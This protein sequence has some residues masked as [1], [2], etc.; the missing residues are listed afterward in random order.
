M[1]HLIKVKAGNTHLQTLKAIAE[2]H[3]IQM[4]ELDEQRKNLVITLKQWFST[5]FS[6]PTPLG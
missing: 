3:H 2:N 1:L 4:K 6:T 5:F